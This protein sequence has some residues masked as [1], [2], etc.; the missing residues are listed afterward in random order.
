MDFYGNRL[1]RCPYTVCQYQ[2]IAFE[3]RHSRDAHCRNHDRPYKCPHPSCDFSVLGFFSRSQLSNHTAKC[4]SNTPANLVDLI[5]NPDE[6]EL[7]P[8]LSDMI[9]M[10][11]ADEVASLFPRFKKLNR[12]QREMLL[13]E[14]AF[15]GSLQVLKC[16]MNTW[17]SS[18]FEHLLYISLNE[19]INGQNIE[20]LER[21]APRISKHTKK[22]KGENL[23]FMYNGAISESDEV[24]EIWK[25]HLSRHRSGRAPC[26]TTEFVIGKIKDPAKQKRFA[27]VI[28][29][30]AALGDLTKHDL[31]RA[32]KAVASTT[33]SISLARTLL[34]NGAD[35]DFGGG[36]DTETREL[37]KQ[38]PPLAL[39]AARNGPQAAEMMRLLLLTG[40][41]GNASYRVECKEETI[42]KTV[43]MG[44][45]AKRVSKW[46][47]MTWDELVEWA[48]EQ[49]S[50]NLEGEVVSRLYS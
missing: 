10:N 45:G 47:G 4:H 11:M 35:V 21:V 9:A 36:K 30:H 40:A 42:I 27:I 13:R 50:K 33:C 24:F 20:I 1:F 49:R 8:L 15:S 34:D 6:D 32:L 5:E 29:E 23:M 44:S 12:H 2:Q 38:K 37:T 46:L 3:T 28:R 31:G 16:I 22:N 43:S 14:A 19:S 39:A 17:S 7:I 48:T 18:D 41:D 26:I 25:K